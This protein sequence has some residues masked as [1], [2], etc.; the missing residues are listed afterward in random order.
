MVIRILRGFFIKKIIKY[1]CTLAN[2]KNMLS[3]NKSFTQ[4][5]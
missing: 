4:L 5:V 1:I 2:V 3:N